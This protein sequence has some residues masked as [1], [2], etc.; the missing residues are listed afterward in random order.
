[1]TIRKFAEAASQFTGWP[2]VFILDSG[3]E[4]RRA[5]RC[6]RLVLK[7][8]EQ[9]ARAGEAR[10]GFLEFGNIECRYVKAGGFDARAGSR[11]RSR[12]NDGTSEGERVRSV[13][14]GKIHVDPVVA[15]QRRGV[16]HAAIGEERIA[17]EVGDGGLEM[18][19]SADRNGDH[20]VIVQG[21]N[22]GK[23]ADTFGVAPLGETHEKFSADAKN[24]AAFKGAG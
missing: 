12:E 10:L 18:Q 11:K 13:G 20:F 3:R 1:M 15:R 24:V 4:R 7:S 9:E 2:L 5:S 19:A 6:L 14:L 8:F 16:K 23:L 17:A 21:E 22:S